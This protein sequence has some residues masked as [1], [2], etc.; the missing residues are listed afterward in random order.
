[1]SKGAS[2]IGRYSKKR[3]KDNKMQLM[4]IREKKYS[5]P[6]LFNHTD[7]QDIY[8]RCVNSFSDVTTNDWRKQIHNLADLY[9]LAKSAVKQGFFGIDEYTD[10]ITVT[11]VEIDLRRA[12]FQ[13]TEACYGVLFYQFMSAYRKLPELG[14]MPKHDFLETVLRNQ[15]DMQLFNNFMPGSRWIGDI[16]HIESDMDTLSL[17]TSDAV[18]VMGSQIADVY[19]SIAKED[20]DIQLTFEEVCFMTIINVFY[21]HKKNPQFKVIQQ[22]VIL[23]FTKYLENKYGSSYHIR[24][25]KLVNYMCQ[26][27]KGAQI[28]RKWMMNG[29]EY[30]DAVYKTKLMKACCISSFDIETSI[31]LLQNL[32]F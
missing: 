31:K 16:L 32:K 26:Y 19:K 2:K 10:I 4:L 9:A 8:I 20:N 6:L 7:A 3:H 12:F 23:A 17:N 29:K 18:K 27:K 21:P 22:R 1:M 25:Q 24:L 5:V 14:E 13:I 28:S 11:G 15:E 30:L